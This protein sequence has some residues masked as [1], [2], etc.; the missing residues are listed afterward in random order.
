MLIAQLMHSQMTDHEVVEEIE[1]DA[2]CARLLVATVTTAKPTSPM[3]A[4]VP[5]VAMQSLSP[6]DA[7]FLSPMPSSSLAPLR[8]SGAAPFKRCPH[9]SRTPAALHF[10]SF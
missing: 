9:V 4:A 3:G 7:G 8:D 1:A 6:G 5:V 2:A 10:C